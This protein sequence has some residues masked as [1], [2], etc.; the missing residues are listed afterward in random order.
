MVI[1]NKPA[2]YTIQNFRELESISLLENILASHQLVMPKI[3]KMDKWPNIDGYLYITDGNGYEKGELKVQVKTI[4]NK[5]VKGKIFCKIGQKYLNY[6]SDIHELVNL[7]IGVDTENKE[8]YWLKITPE[9][10][11]K[12]K[13]K[14]VFFP[15]INVIN[16]NNNSYYKLWRDICKRRRDLLRIAYDENI[17]T[18]TVKDMPSISPDKIAKKI[19]LSKPKAKEINAIQKFF[20][21]PYTKKRYYYNL[22]Y[23]LSPYY[24]YNK[25][26]NKL[27]NLTEK[28]E[29][30]FIEKFKQDGLISVTGNLIIIKDKDRAKKY[31]NEMMNKLIKS[32]IRLEDLLSYF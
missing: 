17:K 6:C 24:K 19:L 15:K 1:L 9:N 26:V 13:D 32:N 12:I 2:K 16:Y 30:V 14:K 23:L 10:T 20:N 21:N 5:G 18:K 4:G 28:K 11:K 8:A 25:K 7:I 22:I 3:D 29:D 31:S 27:L